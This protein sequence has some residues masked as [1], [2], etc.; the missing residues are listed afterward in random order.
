MQRTKNLNQASI[1]EYFSLIKGKMFFPYL[2][3]SFDE[4]IKLY[5]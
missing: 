4:W 5:N 2:S 3:I 1:F